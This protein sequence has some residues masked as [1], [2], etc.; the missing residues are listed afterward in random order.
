MQAHRSHNLL[1][2]DRF[3]TAGY[4]NH[5]TRHKEHDRK[6]NCTLAQCRWFTL[7]LWS[8][9]TPSSL[10]LPRASWLLQVAWWHSLLHAQCTHS[11]IIPNWVKAVAQSQQW[12][13][14]IPSWGQ[15]F[16][17][18]AHHKHLPGT[19]CTDDLM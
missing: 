13:Q 5:S 8:S 2:A 18:T 9:V 11:C 7:V 10:P 15:L 6:V 14:S 3:H 17:T 4:S 12:P 1:V 16:N 19:T